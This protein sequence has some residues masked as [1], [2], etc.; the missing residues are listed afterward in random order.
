MNKS[1]KRRSRRLCKKLH[2]REFAELGV[3]FEADIRPAIASE[4]EHSLASDF[5]SEIVEPRALTL[6]GWISGGFVTCYGRGSVTEEDRELIF[7]WLVAR[8][9]IEAVRVGPLVDAWYPSEHG[10]GFW[11]EWRD[12]P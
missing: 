10:K 7:N 5:L 12:S 1:D 6:G 11:H 3:T 4:M 2:I 9:E 8:P